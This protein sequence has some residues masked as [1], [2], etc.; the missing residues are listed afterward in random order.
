MIQIK[1][2]VFNAFGVNGY[3]LYDET[4]ECLLIDTSCV[5][6]SEKDDLDRFISQQ[7]LKPVKLI[8]THLHVDHVLGNNY[9]CNKYGIGYYAHLKGLPV[10]EKAPQYGALFGIEI[11]PVIQPSGFLEHGDIIHFG[12]SELRV[13]YTPGHADGSICLICDAG[14]FVITGDVLFQNS[15]GRTDLETG[16]FELLRASIY[17]ELFTLPP[18]FRVLPGHGPETAIGYEKLNNSFL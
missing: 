11:S 12:H 18:D 16:N 2:F 10:L 9:I 1:R 8:N 6:E 4:S 7:G 14:K 3:V 17:R 5:S 13:V 15:I